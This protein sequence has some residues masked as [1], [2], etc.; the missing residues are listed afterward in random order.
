MSQ[1]QNDPNKS[2]EKCLEIL[3]P[4]IP[5]KKED[6]RLCYEL[7]RLRQEAYEEYKRLYYEFMHTL[8]PP[9]KH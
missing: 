2:Y 4:K 5:L 7:I 9:K 6:I 8:P 3:D 1:Q